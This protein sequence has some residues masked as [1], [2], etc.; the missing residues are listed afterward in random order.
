MPLPKRSLLGCPR[1]SARRASWRAYTPTP[2]P[3]P[4]KRS[5]LGLPQSFSAPHFLAS[6]AEMLGWASRGLP[7]DGLSLGNGAAVLAAAG[8][9]FI[10]D[11]SSRVRGCHCN[12]RAA[13]ACLPAW[14]AIWQGRLSSSAC[15]ASQAADWLRAHLAAAAS[16][17]EAPP[18]VCA[19]QEARFTTTLELAVRFGKVR[20]WGGMVGWG[21]GWHVPCEHGSRRHSLRW[22]VGACGCCP[23][24]LRLATQ[25]D[26]QPT[27]ATHPPSL[28]RR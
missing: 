21:W 5:L 2:T 6:E 23:S 18:D 19:L 10:V 15:V 25:P 3:T 4:P 9:P 11:P 27:A 22:R 7:G 12:L 8:C 16:P 26:P 1:A 17:G 20:G 13:L 14:P 28:R 24:K